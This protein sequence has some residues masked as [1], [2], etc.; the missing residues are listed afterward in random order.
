MNRRRRTIACAILCAVQFCAPASGISDQEILSLAF[1]S[2][3]ARAQARL[4][5][6]HRFAESGDG[7]VAGAFAG[8]LISVIQTGGRDHLLILGPSS[9]K[10]ALRNSASPGRQEQEPG[11]WRVQLSLQFAAPRSSR[12]AQSSDG[13]PLFG[14]KSRREL[15]AASD[16]Y[17]A[18][19]RLA[20]VDQ[21]GA[22]SRIV[23]TLYL[24]FAR[25]GGAGFFL[26]V[27]RAGAPGLVRSYDSQLR[28]ASANSFLYFNGVET[29]ACSPESGVCP[30]IS[31][32]LKQERSEAVGGGQGSG[33][34]DDCAG[35]RLGVWNLAPR[36]R[37][38][39]VRIAL[40]KRSGP[41][42]DS[43]SVID[44]GVQSAGSYC[45]GSSSETAGGVLRI[46][47]GRGAAAFWPPSPSLRRTDAGAYLLPVDSFLD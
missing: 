1:P 37:D 30:S 43:A 5:F 31:I 12:I 14:L 2:P 32:S 34:D 38:F 19:R 47:G 17:A 13:G 9:S 39:Q 10:D 26:Y 27:R 4:V 44:V 21:P 24:E 11:D 28:P 3:E 33:R 6:K 20:I 22:A 40:L 15:Y 7:G 16:D 46:G 45:L 35:V 36:P 29:Q 42:D 8:K 41:L 25:E 18:L 23:P